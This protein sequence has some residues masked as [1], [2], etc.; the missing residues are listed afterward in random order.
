[1]IFGLA[2]MI[3]ITAPRDGGFGPLPNSVISAP[4]IKVRPRQASTS[5]LMLSSDAA[6]STADTS[7]SRTA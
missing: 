6:V 4:A 1:M 5:A 3:S 7:P 2:L